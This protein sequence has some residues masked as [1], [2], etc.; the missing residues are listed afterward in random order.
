VFFFEQDG[1]IITAILGE[2]TTQEKWH[3]KIIK[4]IVVVYIYIDDEGM[5]EK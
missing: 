1:K 5:A 2:E 4:G 3:H